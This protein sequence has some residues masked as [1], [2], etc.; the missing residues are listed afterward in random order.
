M[1]ANRNR[2]PRHHPRSAFTLIE[3][4]VVIAIIAIL[5]AL[6]LPAL[7]TAKDKARRLACASNL[8]QIAI[9]MNVYALDNDDYVIRLKS[10][11][12]VH[13][14]NALEVSNAEGVESVG[15]RL[16]ARSI[17]T[18]PGR[19]STVGF[20]PLFTPGSGP[21][22]AQWVIGYEYMG[23]MTNWNT[24]AG[25]RA[26][27]SPVKMGSAKPYWVLAADANVRDDTAW[28]NLNDQTSGQAYYW[29][30]IPPH[31]RTRGSIPR[32]GNQVFTDGSAAWFKYED[33]YCFHRY[34][35]NGGVPRNWFWYQASDDFM[36]A[37]TTT[38]RIT[39]A[40]LKTLSAK[41]PRWY[42]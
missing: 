14:P 39:A 22:V 21:N 26:P 42:K 28:G 4:L 5:A 36:Q 1:P 19:K 3:L 6:L 23:G 41:S 20:L 7:A 10:S 18:C 25:L 37:P 9:G 34:I 40:D 29:S 32:G 15:L 8:R 2:E 13:I 12:G 16:V 35:G 38:L 27:H 31:K 17:W 30:D 33:M 24:P 11:G